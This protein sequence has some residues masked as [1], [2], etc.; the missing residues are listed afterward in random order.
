MDKTTEHGGKSFEDIGED[1]ADL[2]RREV[3][4][5]ADVLDAWYDPSPR[6]VATIRDHLAWLM[7]TSPPT[8]CSGLR[9]AISQARGIPLESILVGGGSSSLL[10][11]ALPVLGRGARSALQ[12]DPTYGEYEHI[13][14]SQMGLAIV[15]FAVDRDTYLPD[16]AKLAEQPATAD[17]AV[18][19]NPNNPTGRALSLAD[20]ERVADSARLLIVDETY[21]DFTEEASAETLASTSRNVVVVKSMSKFYALSGMR[22]GYLVAHPDHIRSLESLNPPWSVGLLAQVAAVEALRDSTYYA[23]M[24]NETV[25]L[26]QHLLE[27]L[28][29]LPH[30][31][32]VASE[33]NYVLVRSATSAQAIADRLS[34]QHIFVRQ[35]D[36]QGSWFRDDHFRIAVKDRSTLDRLVDAIE[37]VGPS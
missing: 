12:L 10:F 24:R 4:I 8:Q 6:A 18:L 30:L 21:I 16:I 5:N 23:A 34:E 9:E 32:P 26:R 17:I 35:C 3:V 20:I 37:A 7:K 19:V 25:R 31:T 28:E 36:S 2:S 29:P 13:L 33:A 15:Q 27:R 14:G 1:F 11:T 22:V